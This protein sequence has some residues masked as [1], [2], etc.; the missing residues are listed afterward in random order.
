L[1]LA[2]QLNTA[3]LSKKLFVYTHHLLAWPLACVW[4]RADSR[5]DNCSDI[6]FVSFL[7]LWWELARFNWSCCI[8]CSSLS[9]Y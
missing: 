5:E 7:C 9:I 6:L 3:C 4:W 1:Y 2:F 8:L